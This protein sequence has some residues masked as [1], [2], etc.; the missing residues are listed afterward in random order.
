MKTIQVGIIGNT[1][2]DQNTVNQNVLN[3]VNN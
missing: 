2:K 3:Q 1:V